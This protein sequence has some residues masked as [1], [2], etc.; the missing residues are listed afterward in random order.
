MKAQVA[1]TRRITKVVITRSK[2]G[3]AELAH[4]LR[5]RGFEP[6]CVDTIE[7]LPP[8]EWSGVD[9]SLA[10]LAEFDWVIFTSATGVLFF[11]ERMDALSLPVPWRGRP[12][13]G[14]VG[15]KT[16][17]ALEKEGLRVGFIPSAYLTRA[18]AEG[19]PKGRGNDV[20]VLRA[21]IGEPGFVPTL[22]RRG[23]NV[24]DVPIYRTSQLAEPG[25]DPESATRGADAIVFASP[26]AVEAFM[27]MFDSP[28]HASSMAKKLLALCIG[29]VTSSAAKERGFE[30]ILEPKTHTVD[31]LI[32]R[33]TEASGV[34]RRT[35]R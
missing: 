33:L 32:E 27:N 19:L 24:T 20:L 10:M 6:V 31:G 14:A 25:I 15:E 11:A 9:A 7:F 12:Y 8:A 17:A 5:A 26:S 21:E 16:S 4:E 34:R 13:V 30:R 18:L 35:Q 23:F 2:Q 29:P 3:N 1:G 22:E 28:D